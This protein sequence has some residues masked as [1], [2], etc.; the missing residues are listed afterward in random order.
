ME[1]LTVDQR[2]RIGDFLFELYI[3]FDVKLLRDTKDA[4]QTAWV[5][6][7]NIVTRCIENAF[8]KIKAVN[9]FNAF[10]LMGEQGIEKGIALKLIFF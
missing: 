5:F 10:L 7:E 2:N 9:F 6:L 1:E 8:L 3:E 4:N